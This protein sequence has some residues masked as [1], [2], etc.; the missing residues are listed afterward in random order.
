MKYVFLSV[1]VLLPAASQEAKKPAVCAPIDQAVRGIPN[2]DAKGQAPLADDGEFL[3]RVM[4]DLTGSPPTAEQTKAFLADP[5]PSKRAA[6]IDE[7]LASDEWADLWSRL[8]AEAFFGN[9]HDVPMET[10]PKLSKAASSRIVGD[11]VRWL[12]GKL[13]KDEPWTEVV[14]QILEA[15]GTDQGD[16]ALAWK[17]SLYSEDG[18]TLAFADQVA[19]HFLGIRMI[20]ARCHSHPFDR[21]TVED[22]YGLAAFVARQRVRATGGSADAAERVTLSYVDEG[23]IDIPPLDIDSTVVHA[24]KPGRARPV[25]LFGG[26]APP[27]PVD[28]M[29][30]LSSFVTGKS[31]TQLPRALA[32]RVWGWLFPRGVVHPVD[33]FNLRQNKPLSPALLETLTRYAVESKTSVKALVRA[34]CNTDAYQRSCASDASG[35]RID[36]SKGAVKQLSG[37][38]L[39]NALR[40]ATSGKADRDPA[41][42]MQIVAPLYPPGAVWCEVT[43]LPGNARQA[44]LLRNSAEISGW[45]SGGGVLARIKSLPGPLEEKVDEMFLAA[46]SRRPSDAERRR[47]AS[48]LQSHAANGFEDAYWT[49]LNSPEFVTRH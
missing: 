38:Q 29:K 42:A 17:L 3:R 39:V 45:I 15:R 4:L 41:R 32:N 46:L 22:Y 44:L 19:R 25:F 16:P 11:F 49:I 6:K 35:S 10:S 5:A 26:E 47:Y 7:L 20:C 27:G 48:F 34:I 30:F 37:E 31:N 12:G 21:W 1:I 14:A 9:Y 18:Y 43:P 36:F 23:E 28:R 13:R 8:F 2:Y 33:H 24:G 40:V